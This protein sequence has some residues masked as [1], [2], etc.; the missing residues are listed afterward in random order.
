MKRI[1]IISEAIYKGK[2]KLVNQGAFVTT[3]PCG[4]AITIAC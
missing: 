2:H 4:K 1:N 3:G